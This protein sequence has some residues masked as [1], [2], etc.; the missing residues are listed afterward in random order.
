MSYIDIIEILLALLRASREGNWCLHL[1]AIR[2]MIPWCF[3]YDKQN[4]ARYLSVYHAQ[5]TRLP[6]THQRT[7]QQ[8]HDGGFSVQRSTCNTFGRIPVDQTVEETVNRDTQTAGG[9][10]GF[11]LK[12]SAVSKYY[13][14]AEYRCQS[15]KQLRSI[16]DID[17]HG[18]S[19]VD[20]G[21]SRIRRR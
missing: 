20:L 16:I 17:E 11:S 15:L 7:Y 1:Y 13:L 2:S 14:T 19:H 21:P 3:A 18:L 6:Q 12:P 10:K 8:L 5:M 4:Y 9:T